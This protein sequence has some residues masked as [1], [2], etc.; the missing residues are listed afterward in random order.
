MLSPVPATHAALYNGVQNLKVALS[1]AIR[2]EPSHWI[3]LSG[4][5]GI[6]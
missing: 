2:A 3:M 5:S 4:N 1:I 6:S